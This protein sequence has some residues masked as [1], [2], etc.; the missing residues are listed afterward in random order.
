MEK[1]GTRADSGRDASRP[2]GRGTTGVEGRPTRPG[3]AYGGA[4]I[5]EFPSGEG[6]TEDPAR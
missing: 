5:R 1:A 3:S 6:P 4:A 2:A